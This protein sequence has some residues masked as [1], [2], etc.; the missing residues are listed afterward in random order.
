[1]K[2]IVSAL[3]I[4]LVSIFAL[5]A[6]DGIKLISPVP[7][8]WSN[9][10]M[11]V[12]DT[13][14]DDAEYY[15]SL[16]GSDPEAFGFAYD[17]PVLLDVAGNVDLRIA[18]I[19]G[20]KTET[21]VNYTVIPE[22]S[23][24][25]DYGEFITSFFDSGVLN[26][27][28]GSKISI[29]SS[30]KYTFDDVRESYVTGRDIVISE[31]SVLVR[32]L[33]CT[34]YDSVRGKKWR[35]I[36]NIYPVNAGLFSKRS[37]PFEIQDWTKI[38]FLNSSYIYRID[39]NYWQPYDKSVELDRSVPHVVYWQ[40]VNF[41][42]GNPIEKFILPPKPE[43]Q[44]K[45]E[46]N[47][48]LIYSLNGDSS[49][50]LSLYNET[51]QDYRQLYKEVGVDTFFGDNI[52]GYLEM[53][54]FANSV[55]QGK[56]SRT[57]QI[58][59]RMPGQ[60]EYSSE[61]AFY[62]RLKNKV[63]VTSEKGTELYV[64]VSKPYILPEDFENF[65]PS[66]LSTITPQM[67]D[68]T[69]AGT[70]KT[71]IILDPSDEGAV[72]YVIRAYAK[73]GRNISIVSEYKAVI[74]QYN[75]YVDEAADKNFADGSRLNPF[76]TFESCLEV[77]NNGRFA[78]VRIMGPVHVKGQLALET[79]CELKCEEEGELI[80]QPNST[81]TVKN[82]S[83]DLM[84]CNL[85]MV[86]ENPYSQK[87]IVPVLKLDNSVLNLSNCQIVT[88]FGQNGT[89]IDSYQ[90]IVN[91]KDTISSV[92]A[93]NYGSFISGVKSKITITKSNI[94]VTAPTSVIFA[95]TDSSCQLNNN[96]FKVSGVMGRIAEFIN[97][98]G[99]V[100]N[101]FFKAEL[102]SLNKGS[103]IYLDEKSELKEEN[104]ESNGF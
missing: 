25:F 67:Q 51:L 71:E 89:V 3:S 8:T 74:D 58:K 94:N 61:S 34:V 52:N 93:E 53:G 99:S 62:S 5:F 90:S 42:A 48:G 15:Y 35:F 79:N 87:R 92:T 75:Y 49:Y 80:F 26:Y 96:S 6:Q 10:Q 39:N 55:Y 29:P 7:G 78:K 21:S 16:N 98:K 9:K 40:S 43:L 70:N 60:P 102:D 77:I 37:V 33:P 103:P 2:K 72:F 64:A 38:N 84:D 47:G 13:T 27:T 104:N 19:E 4:F 41:N 59:K 23:Y 14:Y 65:T 54:V 81:L 32:Q 18:R 46:E 95:F 30:L 24:A 76:A 28:C 91:I 11:L 86:C 68:F 31:K 66:G 57:Y 1:M 36:I 17:G 83:L 88:N 100:S 73:N 20:S 22:A 63:T 101:S 85:S 12:I 82:S 45:T 56:I 44:V 50:S 97:S 69:P